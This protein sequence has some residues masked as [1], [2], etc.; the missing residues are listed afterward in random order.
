MTGKI[1]ARVIARVLLAA[2]V[3]AIITSCVR[4]PIEEAPAEQ[5]DADL[6]QFEER[7][8]ERERTL[9]A[10]PVPELARQLT[11]DSDSSV[12]PF[13]SAAV[14]D[15]RRRAR[16]IR[17]KEGS[18]EELA[19][20]LAAT[21][22]EP[23]AS[24]HLGLLALLELSPE[25]YRAVYPHFRYRVLT[26]ALSKAEYFNA[27]GIPHL[28]LTQPAGRAIIG[29]GRGIEPYLHP[30]LD[31]DRPTEVFGGSEA[32]AAHD[33][34]KYRV[35]DYALAL[36]YQ[37]RGTPIELP[38]DPAARDRLI[39]QTKKDA[40]TTQIQQ[41]PDKRKVECVPKETPDKVAAVAAP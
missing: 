27:W 31:L 25:A 2:G 1:S 24:S 40:G 41:R 6:A 4:E 20:E 15:V 35:K 8:L 21:L 36:I 39:E 13:N 26:D 28:F 3:A 32:G 30:L 33:E 7:R 11:A 19:R 22:T 12:E 37:A 38:K 17:Q 9:A 29:E 16:E 23:D 34:Y 14:R 10:M 18:V 5:L